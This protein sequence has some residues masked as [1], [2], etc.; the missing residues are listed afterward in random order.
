VQRFQIVENALPEKIDIANETLSPQTTAHK[1]SSNKE[2]TSRSSIAEEDDSKRQ[3]KDLENNSG[4]ITRDSNSRLIKLNECE[5]EMKLIKTGNYS[6]NSSN[7]VQSRILQGDLIQQ[8][9]ALPLV[10]ILRDMIV[11]PLNQGGKGESNTSLQDSDFNEV[12]ISDASTSGAKVFLKSAEIT[13][14]TLNADISASVADDY[15]AVRKES[16]IAM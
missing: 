6:G 13:T 16:H 12:C 1:I 7:S 15:D 14:T 10:W 3:A 2:Q 4:S 5:K 9:V 11:C 8:Q